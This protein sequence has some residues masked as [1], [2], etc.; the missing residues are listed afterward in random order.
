MAQISRNLDRYNF[1]VGRPSRLNKVG[2]GTG[3]AA[4]GL[5]TLFNDSA[6]AA[7]NIASHSPQQIAALDAFIIQ[8][9]E[10]MDEVLENG[11]LSNNRAHHL[12]DSFSNYVRLLELGGTDS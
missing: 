7:G 6:K 3:L 10:A 5:F 1:T 12:A 2:L 9:D 4:I 11:F 8:Y